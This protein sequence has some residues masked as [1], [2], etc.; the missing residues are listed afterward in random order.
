MAPEDDDEENEN[1]EI[2]A[3][4]IN[5]IRSEEVLRYKERIY[6]FVRNDI[7]VRSF[8]KKYTNKDGQ[9]DHIKYDLDILESDKEEV[10]IV[11]K[12]PKKPPFDKIEE[13]GRRIIELNL[14]AFNQNQKERIK[15]KIEAAYEDQGRL[16][17]S[18]EEVTYDTVEQAHADERNKE[19]ISH[20]N[21][22]ISEPQ[23]QLLQRCLSLRTA[24]EG[25]QFIPT[26]TI[27]EWKNDLADKFGNSARTVANLCSSGYYDKNGILRKIMAE[28]SENND[29]QHTIEQKYKKI[30]NNKPFVVYVG[31]NDSTEKINGKLRQKIKRY[32]S[33][34]YS[35]PFIDLRAQ[36]FS[37]K[38]TAKGAI[39]NLE[40]SVSKIYIEELHTD[41]ERVYRIHPES[42][43]GIE[44][45]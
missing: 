38:E 13:N 19:I 22:Y 30:I 43:E 20:F 24:F 14:N 37:N 36:G 16:L 26:E 39:E 25:N 31:K 4:A 35:V 1:D 2:V 41:E 23:K 42:I 10:K 11:E 34:K 32:D 5:I 28:I 8:I 40:Q 45:N 9:K 6:E 3:T 29:N 7:D 18:E 17:S 15:N 12:G 27:E 44:Y 21:Q 33:Y